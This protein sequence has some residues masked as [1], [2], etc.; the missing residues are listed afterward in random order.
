[1]W[2]SAACR[3]VS[4]EFHSCSCT[5]IGLT[6]LLLQGS[7]LGN[8]RMLPRVHWG[9]NPGGLDHIPADSP[10]I[11]VL[12]H[13]FGSW[14]SRGGWAAKAA[15]KFALRRVWRLL[16]SVLAQQDM[17]SSPARS[18]LVIVSTC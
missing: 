15:V 10:E 1:M 6:C 17:A 13:Y 3:A 7:D 2:I 16:S 18:E 4:S 12:H 9:A 8:V 5:P 11:S 14:K